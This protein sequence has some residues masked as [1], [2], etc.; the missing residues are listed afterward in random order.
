M[1]KTNKQE[2]FKY[3]VVSAADTKKEYVIYAFKGYQNDKKDNPDLLNSKEND[4]KTKYGLELKTLSD[5]GL[6]NEDELL[7]YP[8]PGKWKPENKKVVTYVQGPSLIGVK[9]NDVDDEATRA[10]VKWLI[11][12]TK[13]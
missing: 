6:L 9:A 8:T 7:S 11:S 2:L 3:S 4:F 5:T 1:L 13:K 12:S 10:F